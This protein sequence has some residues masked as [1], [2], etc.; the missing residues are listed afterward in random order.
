M[1][2]HK[3]GERKGKKRKGKGKAEDR[4]GKEMFVTNISWEL[5]NSSH[6][7]QALENSLY[8]LAKASTLPTEIQTINFSD[9]Y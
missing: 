2:C 9:L 7:S 3:F 1:R 4:A 5:V 8:N 6:K